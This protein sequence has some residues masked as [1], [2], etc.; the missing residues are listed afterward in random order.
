MLV[1]ECADDG[2]ICDP[3]GPLFSPAIG[4]QRLQ[5][6]KGFFN[7]RELDEDAFMK[8]LYGCEVV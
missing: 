8:Y 1:E 5:S 3:R 4:A 2:L 6:A 7:G